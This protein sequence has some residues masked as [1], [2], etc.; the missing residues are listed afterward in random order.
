MNAA[1]VGRKTGP[2]PIFTLA[3][4]EAAALRLGIRDFTLTGVA[5]ELGVA[6]PSL[7]RVVDSRQ[8]LL[9]RLLARVA[10]DFRVPDP[11]LSWQDQLRRFADDCW[12]GYEANPGLAEVLLDNPGVHAHIQGYL[13]RMVAG[14]RAAGFPGDEARMEFALDFIGDTALV[15]HIA[16]CAVRREGLDAARERMGRIRP[17]GSRRFVPDDT[18]LDRGFLDG[19]V[20]FIIAGLEAGH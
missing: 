13:D 12:A 14:L 15:T 9:D 20:E 4:V 16:V 5:K 8:D 19:K 1:R 7:Y 11:T 3:D 10:A 2:K 18:W 17:E 6:T